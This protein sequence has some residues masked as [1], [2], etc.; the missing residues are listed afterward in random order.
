MRRRTARWRRWRG[1]GTRAGRSRTASCAARGSWAWATT[2]SWGGAGGSTTRR[3]CCWRCGSWYCKRGGWGGKTT[4]GLT[5]PDTRRLLQAVLAVAVEG[6]PVEHAIT[7][8]DW[9][10][11]RNQVA[12]KSHAKARA[13]ARRKQLRDTG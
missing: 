8:S 3:W 4:T 11:A 1:W 5:V 10:Q 7:L 13:K 9:R 2:R 6:D 12:R